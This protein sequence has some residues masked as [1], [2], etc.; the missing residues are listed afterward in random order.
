MTN[1]TIT[2]TAVYNAVQDLE[3]SLLGAETQVFW[4]ANG[5]VVLTDEAVY[6]VYTYGDEPNV[7]IQQAT[8]ERGRGWDDITA[9]V[10]KDAGVTQ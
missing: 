6:E 9:D 3:Q 5:A 2:P 10:L 4:S 7:I 1:M 8:L